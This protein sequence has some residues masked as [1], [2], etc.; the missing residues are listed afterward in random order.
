MKTSVKTSLLLIALVLLACLAWFVWL[1][2]QPDD[3]EELVG[4]TVSDASRDPS[5]DVRISMPRLGL[6]LGGILPDWLVKKFD[7]TPRELRFDHTRPGA[8]IRSVGTSRLELNADDWELLIET[9]REG[10]IA[11]TTHLVFPLGLGGR[12][13]RLDC[14]PAVRAAG[15]LRST[16]RAGSNQLAGR[17]LVELASCKN[18]E[19]G[20]EIEWPPAPLTVR[21][22]FVGQPQPSLDPSG[23]RPQAQLDK[24]SSSLNL[25]ATLCAG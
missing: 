3:P 13:V 9:D 4:E 1:G 10:R 25:K 22:S 18:A 2:S 17:F 16:T 24:S 19:S 23:E 12:Q 21:G 15:Y 7:G 14:R 11:P 5:F 8:Q 6:P 20:K